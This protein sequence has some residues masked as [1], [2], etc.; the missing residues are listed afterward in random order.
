MATNLILNIGDADTD[1]T[2]GGGLTLAGTL[3]GNG[4]FT[5]G[6]N[7]DTGA[8]DTSDWDIDATGA[9]TGVSFDA[10][11]T[12]NSISNIENADLATDTLDWDRFIDASSLDADTSI[13][14]GAAEELTISKTY[15]DATSENGLILNFTASD[16]TAG[17]TAQYGAYLDNLASTEGLDALLVLDNSDLDDSVGAAIKITNAGGNFTSVIDNAG[18]LISGAELNLLDGHDVAL[19]DTNDA[20]ATAITGTGALDAGSITAN[21]GAIDVGADAI[22]T[23]G[24]IGTASTTTFTGGAGTFSGT[25]TATGAITAN[26]ASADTLL[27][28]QNGGTPDTVTIAGDVS[29]T[30]TQWSITAA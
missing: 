27:L 15:T 7:G 18:T 5:L 4:A 3:D 25:L 11:G 12:G 13:A 8:I 24:T 14:E 17:T 19:V 10:N 29:L 20:V 2:A 22:T 21:F 16:T 6:D 23:S 1:F 28:G 9:I 30:D 26:D